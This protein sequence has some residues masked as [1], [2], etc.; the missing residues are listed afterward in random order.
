M[1][2][3]VRDAGKSEGP[4]VMTGIKVEIIFGV[5]QKQSTLLSTKVVL[6]S[7]AGVLLRATRRRFMKSKST[8]R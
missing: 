5:R 1:M 6:T 2:V 7:Y 4:A 3:Q 8:K